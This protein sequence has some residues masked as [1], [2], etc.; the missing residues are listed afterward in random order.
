M[1]T[2][3][4]KA[5]TSQLGQRPARAP[6]TMAHKDGSFP[7][8]RSPP[9]RDRPTAGKPSVRGTRVGRRSMNRTWDRSTA[10]VAGRTDRQTADKERQDREADER[11]AKRSDSAPQRP[12][13][14]I[15]TIAFILSRVDVISTQ[16]AQAYAAGG[17]RDKNDSSFPDLILRA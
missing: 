9:T 10:Q 3:R 6:G 16:S 11:G 17:P 8:H 5:S 1:E 14:S 12:G 7:S 2:P 15:I 4:P 13:L